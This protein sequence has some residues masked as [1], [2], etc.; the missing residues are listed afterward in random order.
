MTNEAGIGQAEAAQRVFGEGLG[1]VMQ[2]G[3]EG[4]APVFT[5]ARDHPA[6]TPRW[7]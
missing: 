4:R 3:H 1:V 5:L 7:Q 2:M 6:P